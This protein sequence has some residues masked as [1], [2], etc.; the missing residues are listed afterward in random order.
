M[1]T[2]QTT[3]YWKLH[4]YGYK[5]HSY[6]M[7]T[8]TRYWLRTYQ[9]HIICKWS[10]SEL[11]EPKLFVVQSSTCFWMRI[12]NNK[13]YLIV[14]VG[15]NINNQKQSSLTIWEQGNPN[16]EREQRMPRREQGSSRSAVG[17]QHHRQAGRGHQS[18]SVGACRRCF[19]QLV[20]PVLAPYLSHGGA[21]GCRTPPKCLDVRLCLM[22][23]WPLYFYRLWMQRGKARHALSSARKS[24]W[25][26]FT[27]G[28]TCIV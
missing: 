22:I 17:T 9:W 12:S 21:S 8:R 11:S 20:L 2:V 4:W 25:R 5:F 23:C 26:L 6:K 24:A 27:R 19:V 14:N 10:L 1:W 18:C 13:V 15:W 3:T 16:K 7:I 28:F